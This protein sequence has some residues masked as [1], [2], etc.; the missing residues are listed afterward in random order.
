MT[1]RSFATAAIA[2]ALVSGCGRGAGSAPAAED[3][4]GQD[5]DTATDAGGDGDGDVDWDA[6]LDHVF[7]QDH[8]VVIAI[9][10]DDPTA[11]AQMLAA[12]KLDPPQRPYFPA[13]FAF[14]GEIVENVGVRLKGNS[15]L[16]TSQDDQMKS[17]KVHF[18]EYV[19][20]QAFHEAD[21]LNL[22]SNFKD[23]SIMRERLAYEAFAGSGL[24]APRTAYAELWV[25]GDRHG[26]YTLTQQVDHRFLEARY[27]EADHADDGNLYKCYD[28]CPLEYWGEDPEA[29]KS[30]EGVACDDP[31]DCGLQLVTNED[32]P[33]LNDYADVIALVRTVRD[34]RDGA[35]Q[36]EALDALLD[37]E[38]YARFQAVNLVLA[39]L[40]SY[41]GSAHNFYL[42][43]RNGDG[44]FELIPW[45]TNEAYGNFACMGGPEPEDVLAL[46][47]LLP[48]QQ[49]AKPLADLVVGEPALRAAYCAALDELVSAIYT[50]AAQD[51]RVAALHALVGAAR[52]EESAMGQPP[53]N[54]TYEQYLDAQT[55]APGGLPQPGGVTYNL[56]YFNDQRSADVGLQIAELCAGG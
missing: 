27:G 34:V 42:H 5:S 29:Y 52:Q 6:E 48:C 40:D 9:D 23:P 18:E 10:F 47:L 24:P 45:D 15:S 17:F 56:G 19:A 12:G 35:A 32:D 43:R 31:E 13:T 54:Y 33:E 20:G 44:R 28:G 25:D 53:G 30:P 49:P 55:H 37:L 22:N 2:A 26:V 1:S 50:V 41:Y 8:V 38:A 51:D 39:N 7:P 4:A 21:R 46:D 11:Y 16:W 3:D 36:L 14:D